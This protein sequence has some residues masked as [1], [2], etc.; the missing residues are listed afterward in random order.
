[1]FCVEVN[2]CRNRKWLFLCSDW[3]LCW[4][5]FVFSLVVSW[6][7]L[8]VGLCCGKLLLFNFSM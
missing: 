8:V 1:M 3:L 4:C 5:L 2:S 6:L 7:R